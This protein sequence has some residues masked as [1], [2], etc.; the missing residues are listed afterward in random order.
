MFQYSSFLESG[1]LGFCPSFFMF[2]ASYAAI[3]IS[4]SK[5]TEASVQNLAA[6]LILG[7]LAI[8]F[9]PKI[10]V[11][12]ETGNFKY[13][14]IGFFGGIAALWMIEHLVEY[15]SDDG[16]D[17]DASEQHSVGSAN[18]KTHLLEHPNVA[19]NFQ[20]EDVDFSTEA[21]KD[22]K[23][24]DHLVGHV[25]EVD[26]DVKVIVE[27]CNLLIAAHSNDHQGN[28][29][30]NE[31]MF[32]DLDE[33]VHRL[34]YRVDH[35]TRLIQGS[36]YVHGAMQRHGIA[37]RFEDIGQVQVILKELEKTA[38]HIMSHTNREVNPKG[39]V[40]I[41]G[42]LNQF[43]ELVERLHDNIEKASHKWRRSQP[44]EGNKP[45]DH[46]ST[47]LVVPVCIDSMVDGF[48]IGMAFST[49]LNAGIIMALVNSM[50]MSFLGMAYGARYG[51]F[52]YSCFLN[53]LL[54]NLIINV[55]IY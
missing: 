6:G 24:R 43:R 38:V 16:Q 53:K 1:L 34:L 7:A 31:R 39:L 30:N 44:F 19:S 12:C 22:M 8:E 23:H 33:G 51:C 32:D 41:Y 9:F 2:L 50:E 35:C 40:A 27:K 15:F 3:S 45:G 36:E 26:S 37:P 47:S 11:E 18:E 5:F 54:I 42:H 55:F 49:S 20:S 10:K 13:V 14:S 17:D 29:F 21:L 48:V 28:S 4:C 52:Y 46:I 25:S